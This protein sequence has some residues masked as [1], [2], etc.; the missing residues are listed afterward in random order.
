[1]GGIETLLDFLGSL[2]I[3][4][5]L[6]IAYGGIRRRLPGAALGPP[7]LG[8]LFGLVA[9]MQMHMAFSPLPGIVLDMRCV[10]VALAGAFLGV[11]ATV[12]CTAIA[13]AAR[14]QIGGLGMVAGSAGL[15]LAALAG[16]CWASVTADGPRRGLAMLGLAAMTACNVA[17]IVF[18]PTD[19]AIWI[20]TDAYPLIA[21]L[22]FVSIPIVASLMERERCL[23]AEEARMRAATLLGAAE[24]FMPREALDWALAQA[25]TS[26]A[27]VGE[28]VTIRLRLRHAGT[29]SALWGGEA[30]RI[31][32]QT[33]H[34]RLSALLPQG[35]V[36]GWGGDAL[37][38]LAIPAPSEVDLDTLLTR[39]RREVGDAPVAVPGMAPVR[40]RLDIDARRHDALPA[41]R[42]IVA[43]PAA[44]ARRPIEAARPARRTRRPAATPTN[45]S[46][47]LF[48]TFDRLR[49]VRFGGT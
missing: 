36:M 18:L 27:L 44:P 37:V 23:M 26:G 34:G 32:I 19:V 33:L 11:R 39:I 7:V 5:M 1:M 4:G 13:I 8:V 38:L 31:A 16:L 15:V 40:P 43:P 21:A 47:T 46:D 28:V 45:G 2:S 29:V 41:L 3:V 14:L 10:P 25:S 6:S 48:S 42:D 30:R 9:V 12:V 20:L 22:Y 35:G 49:E 17:S 24:G